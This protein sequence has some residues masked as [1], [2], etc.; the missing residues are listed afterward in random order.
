MTRVRGSESPAVGI[1]N[2]MV[3]SQ[4]EKIR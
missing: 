1:R 4:G 3:F 2:S